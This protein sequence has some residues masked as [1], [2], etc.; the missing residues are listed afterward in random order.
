MIRTLDH[1]AVAV[2]RTSQRLPFYRDLLGLPLAGSEEVPGEKVRVT[3]LGEGAG[4]IELLEPTEEDSPVGRFL[5]ERGEGIHHL[6]FRVDSLEATCE[7]LHAS[8]YRLVGGIRAG[9]EG[10]RIAFLHPKDTGGVLIELRESREM[11]P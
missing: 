4:R 11:K 1:V 6:C 2:R 3:M 5:R 9:S 8:G 7:K 10:T